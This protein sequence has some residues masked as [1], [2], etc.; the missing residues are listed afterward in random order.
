MGLLLLL[1]LLAQTA[2]VAAYPSQALSHREALSLALGSYNR[3]SGGQHAFR[4]LEAAPAPAQSSRARTQELSFTLQETVCPN[5]PGL[6][7]DKCDFS[8]D[9]L[10]RA[11]TGLVSLEDDSR[12][13]LVTCDT[14]GRAPL[15]VKRTRRPLPARKCGR[16]GCYGLL[17][18]LKRIDQLI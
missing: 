16:I 7:L 3:Q 8:P 1:I 14:L 5:A 9:G 15:R 17:R 18:R 4:L 10:V 13:I 12:G 2:G 6:E 11:C